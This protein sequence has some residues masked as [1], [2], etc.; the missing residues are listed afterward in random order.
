VLL[1]GHSFGGFVCIQLAHRRPELVHTMVLCAPGM[2]LPMA[3]H[4]SFVL[5]H[6]FNDVLPALARFS[7][8]CTCTICPRLL[9]RAHNFFVLSCCGKSAARM[10]RRIHG[11][12]QHRV[13]VFQKFSSSS[14]C[15][16]YCWVES[17]ALPLLAKLTV[18]TA[19]ITGDMD[20]VAP[21]YMGDML[22]ALLRLPNIV[23]SNCGHNVQFSEHF[24]EAFLRAKEAAVLIEASAGVDIQEVLCCRRWYGTYDKADSIAEIQALYRMLMAPALFSG[25]T[26]A[27]G[28]EDSPVPV[29]QQRTSPP[30]VRRVCAAVRDMKSGIGL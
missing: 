16:V 10:I 26:L 15:G 5:K 12:L 23:I 6:F 20:D 25:N 7:H 8:I 3:H 22:Q 13:N 30:T 1:C 21:F 2:V 14:S 4:T 17:P 9:M 11:Q 29:F 19:L 24:W 28:K 27:A 18:P